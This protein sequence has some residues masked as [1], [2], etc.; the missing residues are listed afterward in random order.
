MLIVTVALLFG[1]GGGGENTSNSNTNLTVPLRVAMKNL[2]EKGYG[3]TFIVTQWARS[4]RYDPNPIPYGLGSGVV[5]V[6]PAIPTIWNNTPA[7][8]QEYLCRGD[9][10]FLSPAMHDYSSEYTYPDRVKAGDS[11]VAGSVGHLYSNYSVASDGPDSLLVTFFDLQIGR[12]Q[13]ISWVYRVDTTGNIEPISVASD[14]YFDLPV[15]SGPVLTGLVNVHTVMQYQSGNDI[16]APVNMPPQVTNFTTT[17]ATLTVTSNEYGTGY[18]LVKPAF[19]PAPSVAEVMTGITTN[20]VANTPATTTL[21]G[22][23]YNTSYDI[24]FVAKDLMD[25]VQTA[26]QRVSVTTANANFVAQGGLTWM[27]ITFHDTWAN[28]NAYC[29]SSGRRMPSTLELTALYASGAM[30]GQGWDL[31]TAWASDYTLLRP[32]ERNYVFLT[33]NS[34]SQIR[35]ADGTL[36]AMGVSCVQ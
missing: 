35:S 33:Y 13:V 3:K 6:K 22:L 28:A 18:Y 23:T 30:N 36:F 4:S 2:V 20:L 16:A 17:K 25:H 24:Y 9:C 11:G 12:T 10:I 7:L 1:C 14:Q 34:F 15:K 21:V 32:G 19:S 29:A 27:P 8:S 26:A 5:A 31:S